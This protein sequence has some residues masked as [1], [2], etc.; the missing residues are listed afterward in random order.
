MSDM[1]KFF[2]EPLKEIKSKFSGK[3]LFV[4]DTKGEYVTD[5]PVIIERAMGFFDYVGVSPGEVGERVKKTVIT[6]PITITEKDEEPA[7][8]KPE[9][10]G[11]VCTH[12]GEVHDK[13]V[14]YA[15][16]AKKHKKEG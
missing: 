10:T 13:P 15:N 16:C 12:C 14:D 11:K 8:D 5:D 7:E 6:P 3:V 2:G 9:K 4:F 1:V